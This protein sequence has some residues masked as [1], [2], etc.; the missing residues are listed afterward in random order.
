MGRYN[1]LELFNEPRIYCLVDDECSYHL[2]HDE[3]VIFA[4]YF[5]NYDMSPLSEIIR[6]NKTI[7]DDF[8]HFIADAMA[9]CFKR[10]S[11]KKTTTTVRD[12]EIYHQIK[13]LMDAD[14]SLPLRCNSKI[15]GAA[16]LVANNFH[17]I[18]EAIA[19]K[20]YQKIKHYLDEL[21]QI[22]KNRGKSS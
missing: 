9:G 14:S 22:L 21:D 16:Q 17:G 3:H 19:V 6:E 20:A 18:S 1:P 5:D 15:E 10:P 12:F 11:K 13:G 4:K 2:S 8:R 7:T